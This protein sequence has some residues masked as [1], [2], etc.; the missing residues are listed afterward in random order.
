MRYAMAIT[1]IALLA[2][3]A[4]AFEIAVNNIS[5]TEGF[6]V[7]VGDT[8]VRIKNNT[9]GDAFKVYVLFYSSDDSK[10]IISWEDASRSDM[11]YIP[12][13][14]EGFE[15]RAKKSGIYSGQFDYKTR[16]LVFY[17]T[18]YIP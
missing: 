7:E 4:Y 16:A 9:G 18:E 8:A 12:A 11:P 17:Q 10:S 13:I 14:P 15:V 6:M 5:G 2:S 3:T 1:L